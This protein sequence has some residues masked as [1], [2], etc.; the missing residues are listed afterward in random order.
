MAERHPSP[1][2]WHSSR[3]CHDLDRRPRRAWRPTGRARRTVA[4][5]S[6]GPSQWRPQDLSVSSPGPSTQAVIYLAFV[7]FL[8]GLGVAMGVGFRSEWAPTVARGLVIGWRF[9]V[10]GRPSPPPALVGA[11]GRPREKVAV[12]RLRFSGG[13]GSGPRRRF[14]TEN[15][16]QP[17]GS[18]GD[19][20]HQRF[21][22]TQRQR[23][24]RQPGRSRVSLKDVASVE[25]VASDSTKS[26]RSDCQP[27]YGADPDESAIMGTVRNADD[28]DW[29]HCEIAALREARA[30]AEAQRAQD[31]VRDR[32]PA[33][34][35]RAPAH[36]GSGTGP[37]S[38]RAQRGQRR[39]R[40]R[41]Q[42]HRTP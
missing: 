33:G 26:P 19:F 10:G 25:L 28:L 8:M 7:A 1:R 14:R 21:A 2:G 20:C 40:Q 22:S 36:P 37:P 9:G 15:P 31:A 30:E 29:A 38:P 41:P 5:R 3:D 13:G 4:A 18:C 27:R 32:L 6:R 39:P 23:P 16:G 17:R 42:H 35:A 34:R 24:G 12:R 11:A